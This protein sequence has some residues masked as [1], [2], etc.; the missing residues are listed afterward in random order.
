MTCRLVLLAVLAVLALAGP[1]RA[2]D[3]TFADIDRPHPGPAEVFGTYT[4][5]CFVGGEGLALDGVGY[6][7][8]RPDRNR[9]YGHPALM[10]FLEDFGRSVATAGLGV[11]LIAD[12]NQ[13]MGGPISGH[14]SH[15]LGL[16]A[17]IWL[18][19]DLPRL[20]VNARGGLGAVVMVDTSTDD[21]RVNG[22]FTDAQAEL[23][24]L[25]AT[26]PR[27][28]RIFVH[29]AIKLAMC[30]RE[31]EDRSF[32]RTIRPWFGHTSHMHVRL[33]CPADSPDCQ[34][35][36]APPPGEGCGAELMSWWPDP[37]AE[38]PPPSPP[39]PAPPLP[40]Q[41]QALLDEV[42]VSLAN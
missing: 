7:V 29:P 19:L 27:V 41:C 34:V 31:W 9:Y 6:Q 13:P 35:Q 11:A 14:A 37:N 10:D 36:A 38:P 16:D 8:I 12:L 39:R 25:A 4:N 17:D 30:E 22:Q 3:M 26:D 42:D 24:R 40:V 33:H 2:Q 23:I 32:L 15:E 21:W 20:P 1:A 18:R 28:N 5:G